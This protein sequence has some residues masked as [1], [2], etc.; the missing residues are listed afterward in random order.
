MTDPFQFTLTAMNKLYINS[1][2]EIDI[3]IIAT[4]EDTP[5]IDFQ[6]PYHDDD[7]DSVQFYFSQNTSIGFVNLTLNGS[8][9]Y[10]PKQDFVGS[11]MINLTIMDDANN[12]YIVERTIIIN[13]TEENDMPVFGFLYNNSVFDVMKNK[14]FTLIFEGNKTSHDMFDFGFGDVDENENLS[15]LQSVTNLQDV[16]ITTTQTDTIMF[17]THFFKYLNLK[18]SQEYSAEMTINKNFHGDFFY[19]ILGY[20]SKNFYTERL[21]THIYILWSPCVNGIC[22]PKFNDSP[23]CEDVS[24]AASFDSYKCDCYPGY[25]GEW[26]EREINE[27]LQQPCEIFY[28]CVDKTN[29][30]ECVLHPA[31]VTSIVVSGFII[32]CISG[33]ILFW[34]L[35]CK[36]KR[37]VYR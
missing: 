18:T 11:D 30:Y 13:V 10:Y 33:L 4:K 35:G 16:H 31:A 1:P 21:E 27:C 3:D 17:L 36:G 37:Q 14:S 7:S 8:L 24:R 19:Y 23:P 12:P 5:I 29:S 26:C 15:F 2:P 32:T 34:C 6:I 28:N 25:D 20:D 9:S 22:S